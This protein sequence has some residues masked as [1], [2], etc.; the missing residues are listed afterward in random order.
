[1]ATPKWEPGRLYAPG[2]LVVPRA[3]P[4]PSPQAIVNGDFENGGT[5]WNPSGPW[6]VN[7]SAGTGRPAYQGTGFL[8]YTGSGQDT[9]TEATG[10]AV[11][12]GQSVSMTGYFRIPGGGDTAGARVILVWYRQD[13]SIISI[14]AA[15]SVVYR[16]NGA[17]KPSSVT[18]TA[19]AGAV[20]V[21]AGV[22]ATINSGGGYI[23]IDALSWTYVPPTATN[24]QYKAVQQNAGYSGTTEP[25]WPGVLGQ[26][27]V[28]NE[29]TWEAVNLSR[30]VWEARP[31]LRSGSTEP[32]WPETPGGMVAD[33][34]ISWRAVS[35]RVEDE[36]C[37]NTKQVVIAASKVFAGDEDIIAYSATVDPL[38]WSTADDAGYLPFGLQLYGANPV[39]AMGLYRGNV[40]AFNAQGAQV[41]QVDEDPRNMQLL[42]AFPIGTT[43]HHSLAPVTNDLFMLTQVGVRSMG[44]AG[45]ATNLQAGDVGMPIDPLVQEAL[46]TARA[47]GIDPRG[48]YNPNAGQ[49]WL[50][51]PSHSPSEAT[52]VFVYTMNRLGQIGAWTRYEFPFAIDDWCILGNDLYVRSGDEIRRV[53]DTRESDEMRDENG[54][55]SPVAFDWTLQWPWLDFGQIGQG[56]MMLGFDI[57]GYGAARI[58]FGYDQSN[59]GVWTPEWQLIADSVP[60]QLLPM[61]LTAP[62]MAIRLT[63]TGSDTNRTGWEALNLHFRPQRERAW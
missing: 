19:P 2:A 13:N 40:V 43:Y 16:S 15:T 63:Y 32:D 36:R 46:E 34:T 28:D 54:D 17:W 47:N 29:V 48:L 4:T 18:A 51:F 53:T 35:R 21:R 22:S 27:V 12:P 61:P 24:L 56:K 7:T 39:A 60:G 55:I 31:I 38:D 37:P 45:G 52:T 30:V 14:S 57:V 41:W 25:A 59:G 20:E 42:D 1:M 5:N 3:T 62:S 10:H 6:A 58:Q 44:I 9:I 11:V 49:Y 23:D 33:N 8:T 50:M 26:T